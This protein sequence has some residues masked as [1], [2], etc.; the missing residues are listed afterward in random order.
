VAYNQPQPSDQ[1]QTQDTQVKPNPTIPAD[2][3]S[4]PPRAPK[5]PPRHRRVTLVA[6]NIRRPPLRWTRIVASAALS[7][8]AAISV[9]ACGGSNSPSPSPSGAVGQSPKTSIADAYKYS[10]CMRNHGVENFPDPHVS[11]SSGQQSINLSL[12]PGVAHSLAFKSARNAC[13]HLVPGANSGPSAPQQQA[14]TEALVSFAQCMR[15]HGFSRFPDPNTQGQLSP[16]QIQSAGINLKAP[17]V[18]PAADA[19]TSVTHG[20]ITKADVAQAIADDSGSQAQPVPQP[21]P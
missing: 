8:L 3:R 7:L 5:R 12:S 10:V 1:P 13:G 19:C 9:A 11:S 4:R 18:Q 15:K 20:Q 6:A 16:T 2:S 14:Q 21:A 17:A